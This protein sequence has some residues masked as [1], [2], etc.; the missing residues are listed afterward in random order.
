M[1]AKIAGIFVFILFFNAFNVVSASV[2]YVP[3][4]YEKIQWAVDMAD[5]ND[6]III[7]DGIYTE[8]IFVNKQLTI[9]SENGSAN[10]IIQAG[11]SYDNV[12]EV[13][14]DN[15]TI[16]GFT[17]R[18]ATGHWEG[19]DYLQGY[20]GIFL[21]HVQNCSI[22]ENN[23]S[24]NT[25]GVYLYHSHKNRIAN[26]TV[27]KSIGTGILLKYSNENI[28][29]NNTAYLN[30]WEGTN[31]QFEGIR[32]YSSSNNVVENNLIFKNKGDGILLW[33]SLGN[34]ITNNRG[35]D[36]GDSGISLIDSNNN[37]I[38]GNTVFNNSNGIELS[39]SNDNAIS[40]N[41]C[42]SNTGN[43]YGMYDEN[44][45]YLYA[46]DYNSLI[47]NTC[48]NNYM[49]IYLSSSSYNILKNNTCS[50]GGTGIEISESE[51][52]LLTN[53]NCSNNFD[54]IVLWL[55]NNNELKGNTMYE[56][57]IDIWGNDLS[58]YLHEI[59]ATNTVNEKPVYYWKNRVGGKVPEGAGQIILVNCRNVVIENQDL[60][61]GGTIYVAHSSNITI[62]KNTCSL[63]N[64]DCITLIHSNNN[65]IL[66]NNLVDN[67]CG[68][69]L[70]DSHANRVANN[71]CS[72]HKYGVTCIE[73]LRSNGNM[74][75]DN[76][77]SNSWGAAISISDS[78][79]NTVSNNMLL[80]N[81]YAI[82][83]WSSDKN[84][85]LNNY[86]L[87][88]TKFGILLEH[89]N[90]N[91]IYLNNFINNAEN[92]HSYNS[93]N[94]WNSTSNKTYEYHN[95]IYSNY[96]GNYWDDYTGSDANGDGIGDI[97]YP[98]NN[99]DV[100]YYPLIQ[101]WEDYFAYILN[102]PNITIHSP[103]N[104][105]YATNL[106]PLNV[107]ANKEIV[108][109]LYNLNNTENIS[110]IPNKTIEASEGLNY[111]AV[112]ANDTYG[113][114]GMAE[115]Y[116]TVD[117]FLPVI[118]F[119]E[120]KNRTITNSSYIFIN[121]TSNEPL[122]TCI[123]YWNETNYTMEGSG[124]NWYYTLTPDN[125]TY[126]YYV[127]GND[128]AGNWNCTENRTLTVDRIAPM[129]SVS[130]EPMMPYVGTTFNVSVN[131]NETNPY[132]IT[133]R[134]N[135]PNGTTYSVNIS[136][137]SNTFYAPE[138]GIY[139]LEIVAEDLAGNSNNTSITFGVALLLSNT[140][141]YIPNG[142]EGDIISE[143][144]HVVVSVK[145][146]ETANG[147]G[148]M[149][150]TVSPLPAGFGLMSVDESIS[151]TKGI[152]YINVSSQ[153][154]NITEIRI[155]LHYT[156]DEI[157]GTD[158]SSLAMFFWNGSA[159]VNC[160]EYSG[161]V[162]KGAPNTSIRDLKVFEAGNNPDQNYVYAVVNHTSYYGLG[163]LLDT[164]G[165]GI[166]DVND[167]CPTEPENYNGYQDGD[168][169]PDAKPSPPQRRG[170]GGGGGGGFFLP[171][172]TPTPTPTIT[173]TTTSTKTMPS[174]P[175]QLLS[176]PEETTPTET[177]TKIPTTPTATP[178]STQPPLMPIQPPTGIIAIVSI[179][180]AAIV[181]LA[182]ILR[183]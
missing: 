66:S 12:F 45:I 151:E 38:L 2:V 114:T 98:V 20:H 55:S 133:T 76:D 168:G 178:A 174:I 17:I 46:S 181:V 68:V 58:H 154:S 25:W 31:L 111:L 120:L 19:D 42:S 48:I 13:A 49:G 43:D 52:N 36:N 22:L 173:P 51:E 177:P 82:Y 85:I 123:L 93:T 150:V 129:L 140:S 105:T 135:Y 39:Y 163:G 81:H 77:L 165:D 1:V 170:R 132:N 63:S 144:Q 96:T 5:P 183:R 10:C 106:I 57:G 56:N 44:G 167:V 107:T 108:E 128:T 131:I 127:C 67:Y 138:Y 158:E 59:D 121:I 122:S 69:E 137:G 88:S 126:E 102:P 176:T 14:A 171:T 180:V 90:D 157:N 84:T 16:K 70:I 8:N 47:N 146:N 33:Y 142:T 27:S 79:N 64:W 71:N 6:T 109:W 78:Y 161:G 156:D 153:L 3:D 155:E 65:T 72:P 166:P 89:S 99:S 60:N 130:I 103:I 116:F 101:P 124:T 4:E 141:I 41:N 86:V 182:Y 74:I 23:I 21:D 149:N 61:R 87:S 28:I 145:P 97:P 110:F 35:F 143:P 40:D 32:L 92:V 18:G 80:N 148:L 9:L 30:N 117:T 169:C 75:S 112:Y 62:E 100:D 50:N 139:N 34:I 7:R 29:V 162:I 115:V 37:A 91:A 53:N 172:P 83:L 147:T 118:N 160:T 164:D 152:K 175:K 125:G 104:T 15:V 95:S 73:L 94:V 119:T 24:I 26:N 159:W 136:L 134:L 113:L 11:D 179:I 54:G